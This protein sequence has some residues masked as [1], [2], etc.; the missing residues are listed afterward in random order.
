MEATKEISALFTLIDDPDEEVYHAVSSR[1]VGIGKPIIPHLEN[2][3]ENTV[4]NYLQ[5]RIELLIH[6]LHYSE[7]SEEF[8]EWAASENPDLLTGALLA[9]KFHYPELYTEHVLRDINKL[10]RNTWLELN[11]QLTPLEEIN[12]ISGMLYNF[13]GLN[14]TDT[15]YDEPT[16]FL[17]N[18]VLETKKGN[19]LSNGILYLVLSEMLD[20]PVKALQIPGQFILGYV[21]S[22]PFG[23]SQETD[24]SKIKFFVE[25][26]TGQ[27]YT[28]KDVNDYLARVAEKGND[29]YFA[30]MNNRQVIGHLLQEFALCFTGDKELHKQNELKQ[31]ATLI[32]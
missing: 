23:V 21:K 13:F 11:N 15:V 3:W 32:A 27:V 25:P 22:I 30:P 8:K 24:A 4:D 5:E 6:Q 7:L 20:L 17:L 31:L 12:V 29:H 14:G 10:K 9:C 16:L 2:L 28:I 26:I 18:K 1:I 19:Q